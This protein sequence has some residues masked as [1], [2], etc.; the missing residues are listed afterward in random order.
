MLRNSAAAT[1]SCL[2]FSAL[3]LLGFAF[4]ALHN[5]PIWVTND[6]KITGPCTFVVVQ[7]WEIW[8]FYDVQHERIGRLVLNA[9]GV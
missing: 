2:F 7:M 1:Q 4:S 5:V 6:Q 9:L 3:G 8:G